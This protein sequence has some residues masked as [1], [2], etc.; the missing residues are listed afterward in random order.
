MTKHVLLIIFLFN[1]FCYCA[2]RTVIKKENRLVA[3]LEN[4]YN[5]DYNFKIDS[6]LFLFDT[7]KSNLI[8]VGFKEILNTGL[9]VEPIVVAFN[10]DSLIIIDSDKIKLILELYDYN[11]N[12]GISKEENEIMIKLIHLSKQRIT[13][14]IPRKYHLLLNDIIFVEEN[15]NLLDK[16]TYTQMDSISPTWDTYTNWEKNYFMNYENAIKSFKSYH[17][18]HNYEPSINAFIKQKCKDKNTVV[19]FIK[20]LHSTYYIT[21]DENMNVISGIVPTGPNCP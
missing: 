15:M 19:Y 8:Y 17:D 14:G 1:L 21:I 18:Y 13:M 9:S 3:K 5:H 10:N 4:H 20:N 12:L 2:Q 16:F 11:G 6:N 7:I